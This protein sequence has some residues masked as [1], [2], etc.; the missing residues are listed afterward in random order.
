MQIQRTTMT[1]DNIPSFWAYLILSSQFNYHPVK[2]DLTLGAMHWRE[3]QLT[4]CQGQTK[5]ESDLFLC[6]KSNPSAVETVFTINIFF[7][8]IYWNFL[9]NNWT[10]GNKKKSNDNYLSNLKKDYIYF[11][12]EK[13]VFEGIMKEI[14]FL[15]IFWE[16]AFLNLKWEF[17][18]LTYQ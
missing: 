9:V 12:L 2:N 3:T 13:S 14:I 1:Y 17:I 16:V 10:S 6:F 11:K 7:F 5:N 8:C 15:N 18:Y 4:L